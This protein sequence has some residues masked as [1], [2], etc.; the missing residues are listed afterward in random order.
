MKNKLWLLGGNP[1]SGENK[2]VGGFP[3]CKISHILFD[4]KS[5]FPGTVPCN[6]IQGVRLNAAIRL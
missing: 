5:Y 2:V 4:Y 6:R 1:I 3:I